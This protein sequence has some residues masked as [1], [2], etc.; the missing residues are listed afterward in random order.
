MKPA[1]CCA[2]FHKSNDPT[3][4]W[5]HHVAPSS[6]YHYTSN[7]L[8]DLACS[9]GVGAAWSRFDLVHHVTDDPALMVEKRLGI[10]YTMNFA[11]PGAWLLLGIIILIPAAFLI[12]RR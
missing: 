3:G 11:R 1:R 4:W 7:Y 2:F 8:P 5:Y 10:G 9:Q 6:E 12:V